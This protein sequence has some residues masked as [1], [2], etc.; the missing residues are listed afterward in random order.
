MH[1]TLVHST[2]TSQF[3][4]TQFIATDDDTVHAAQEIFS[5]LTKNGITCDVVALRAE[6][7]EQQLRAIQHTDCIF[8]L[9][10]WT[11]SDLP[12]AVFACSLIE[13]LGIPFTG[14]TTY[15]YF[16]VSDK[17]HMKRAFDRMHIPTALWQSFYCGDE[18]VSSTL[19]YPSIVKP[20]LQHCSIGLS[21]DMIVEKEEDVLEKVK[22][23]MRRFSGHVFVEEFIDGREFHVAVLERDGKPFVLPPVE[24][25]FKVSGTQAFLTYESRWDVAHPDYQQSN[26]FVPQTY[27]PKLTRKIKKICE[28]IFVDLDY[29]DYMRVDMRVCGDDIFVLEA[30]CNPGLGEDNESAIT[31]AHRAIGMSFDEFLLDIVRSCMRRF[32]KPFVV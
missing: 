30:N 1:V 14:A 29:R 13:S 20:A 12:Y 22:L 7:I 8:N 17:V 27:E 15:N 9:V 28:R 10:E 32:G 18:K 26:I 11:G 16:M 21:R 23:Q 6:T 31:L 24:I 2:P 3:L 25:A 5:V 4:S 19:V